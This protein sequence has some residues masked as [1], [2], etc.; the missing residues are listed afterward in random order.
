MQGLL[1]IAPPS[2][3]VVLSGGYTLGDLYNDLQGKPLFLKGMKMVVQSLAQFFNNITVN[4]YSIYGKQDAVQFQPL[5]YV[6]PTNPNSL[7]IDAGDFEVEI[8]GNTDFT[9]D[10]DPLS[11]LIIS[12]TVNKSVDNT[13]PLFKDITE[14]WGA[15]TDSTTNTRMTGNPIAD[16]AIQ[17][18]AN[19]ILSD[20]KYS[21]V[22]QYAFYPR[23][24]GNPVADI[25]LLNQAGFRGDH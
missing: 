21:G 23:E 25:A 2:V 1:P 18:E 6:S 22:A 19:K 17:M 20:S 7:I 16:I 13:V 9:F 5:N 11:S 3:V 4:Y 8:D 10:V 14:D 12:F 24:T 15:G